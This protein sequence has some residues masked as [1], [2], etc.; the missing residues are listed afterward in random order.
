MSVLRADALWPQPGCLLVP[1]VC[2]PTGHVAGTS[3][4]EANAGHPACH[5]VR[6][7]WNRHEAQA[8]NTAGLALDHQV[9]E[10]PRD[11][12]ALTK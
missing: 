10:R 9:S 3:G 6:L 11:K 1:P 8:A 7:L 4:A 2:C 5:S 12:S